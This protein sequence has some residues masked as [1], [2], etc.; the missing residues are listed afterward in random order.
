MKRTAALF[1]ATLSLVACAPS[2][3][4]KAIPADS[5]RTGV[6][7]TTAD[8]VTEALGT[9]EA[10][11]YHAPNGTLFEGGCTPDVALLLIQAQPEMRELK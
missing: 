6:T 10:G 11:S 3:S 5:H 2:Y 9:V 8:N 4:W 1:A 7:A